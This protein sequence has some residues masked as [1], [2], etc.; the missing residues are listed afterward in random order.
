MYRLQARDKYLS[1]TYCSWFAQQIILTLGQTYI[2]LFGCK[3]VKFLHV[4][5]IT[6]AASLDLIHVELWMI[7]FKKIRSTCKCCHITVNISF[8]CKRGF[9]LCMFR[10]K[11]K[12]DSFFCKMNCIFS[13]L[14][15]CGLSSI[16]IKLS[17]NLGTVLL[18]VIYKTLHFSKIVFTF[19]F[20][21]D[22]VDH[23]TGIVASRDLL[24]AFAFFVIFEARLKRRIL[25]ALNAFKTKEI[26]NK[27]PIIFCFK[28]IRL[29]YNA[30]FE[31][32]LICSF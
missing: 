8:I 20:G 14:V 2:F 6:F 12:K 26:E 15:G 10:A 17:Q 16:T 24:L 1:V 4:L 28:Y 3:S 13:I 31:T 29:R 32:S 25:D 22:T 21:K 30:T 11:H 9:F 23:R 27:F 19:A 7:Y 5:H 18:D